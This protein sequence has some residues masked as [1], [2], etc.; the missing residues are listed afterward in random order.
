MLIFLIKMFLHVPSQEDAVKKQLFF[1]FLPYSAAGVFVT[2]TFGMKEHYCQN[3]GERED[4]YVQ[5]SLY[6]KITL[7]PK[8][9]I[10]V[11][12]S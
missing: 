5:V 9:Q 10:T 7:K 11:S 2:L 1:F 4:L 8:G 6:L 3:N 12:C